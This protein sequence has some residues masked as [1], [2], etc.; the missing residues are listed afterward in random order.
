MA[1]GFMGRIDNTTKHVLSVH[2]RRT[3]S[4]RVEER[5]ICEWSGVES[6]RRRRS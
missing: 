5:R 1:V 3:L 2:V 6:V 4:R